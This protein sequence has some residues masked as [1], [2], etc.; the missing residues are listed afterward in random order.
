M[1]QKLLACRTVEEAFETVW[2]G[3]EGIIPRDRIGLSFLSADGETLTAAYHK[4]T[5]HPVRLDNTYSAGLNT[6]TLRHLL[7]DNSIRII[8]DLG[9]YLRFHPRSSST[10]LLIEEGVRSNLTLPL[11]VENRNVGFL[12]FSSRQPSAF[13]SGHACVLREILDLI[14]AF[15]EKAWMIDQLS[16]TRNDYLQMLGFVA[17]E[18]KAPLS[19]LTTMGHMYLE[20]YMGTVDE[21]GKDTVSKMLKLSDYMIR[22]IQNYLGL[23]QLETGEMRFKPQPHVHFRSDI[24]DFV[25]QNLDARIKKSGT[26]IIIEGPADLTL[27]A[28]PDLLRIV[29]TNLID[30]AI[31]YGLENGEVNIKYFIENQTLQFFIRNQGVGFTPEQASSLFKRFSR[32]RQKGLEDRKGTGLGLYLTWWIIQKHKGHISAYSEPG[33][34][35][36]FRVELPLRQT[37]LI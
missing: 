13:T 1:R 6:S 29:F 19:T 15:I 20:G 8:N 24:L 5:Y 27:E 23:S 14:A 17:H 21:A 36:E 22:M 37:D 11:R 28:D 26:R 33:Q 12:F 4:A 7:E 18:L 30:N 16:K 34:W 25:I 2:E 31:K 3:T 35:A 32:L 10:R 9:T